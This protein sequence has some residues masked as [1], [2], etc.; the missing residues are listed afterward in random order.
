MPEREVFNG[1][2]WTRGRFDSFITSILRSGSRRW[3]PK[4]STLN[5]AKTEKRT[6]VKTGRMAQHYRCA[7][8]QE[9]FTQKDIEIDH[10]NPIGREKT[11]DQFIDGLFCEA[12]NLQAICKPCHKVK[13]KEENASKSSSAVARGTGQVRGRA[14][15]KGKQSS[16]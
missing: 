15:R 3:G 9:E 1:G 8:C 6:N 7:A 2:L 13:T 10:I 12:D 5:A 4:Y 14:K 11:W 16:D